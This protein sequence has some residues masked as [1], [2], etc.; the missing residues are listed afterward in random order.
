MPCSRSR[1]AASS[2]PS[3]PSS[4]KDRIPVCGAPS[5]KPCS[6]TLGTSRRPFARRRTRPC[7]RS[8]AASTPCSESQRQAA[9]SPAAPTPLGVPASSRSGRC[10]GISSL[11]EREPVP[12][13][14]SGSTSKPGASSRTPIPGGPSRP[15]CP[16]QARAATPKARKSTGRPPTVCAASRSTGTGATAAAISAA[17]S[18]APLTFEA[19]VSTTS[20]V[21]ASVVR[22][23]TSAGVGTPCGSSPRTTTTST[24]RS[25]SSRRSGRITALCSRAEVTTRAP[26]A[27]RSASTVLIQKVAPGP[28]RVRSGSAP[29]SSA[30]SSRAASM[31]REAATVS[32]WP[33]RPGLPASRSRK[34]TIAS[35]TP[36]ALGK[37]VAPWSR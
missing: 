29:S 3:L 32:R 33:P 36:G 5:R 23:A 35:A 12:P 22:A 30:T 18:T 16:E 13:R 34:R 27:S 1:L 11:S 21:G 14:T 2:P 17:G 4:V 15:L 24:P 25:A 7:R 31:A 19:W 28:S 20:A 9:P 26:G 6:R 8:R 37:A 10:S